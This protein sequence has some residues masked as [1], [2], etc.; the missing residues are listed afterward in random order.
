MFPPTLL[1]TTASLVPSAPISPP[2]SL[3]QLVAA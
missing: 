3:T 2:C 1:P